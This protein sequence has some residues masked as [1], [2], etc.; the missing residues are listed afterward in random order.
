MEK[1]KKK[2]GVDLQRWAIRFC[3]LAMASGLYLAASADK[4]DKNNIGVAVAT[5]A[6][7]VLGGIGMGMAHCRFLNRERN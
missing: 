4:K 2:K 1:A 6:S 5:S 3:A 7:A